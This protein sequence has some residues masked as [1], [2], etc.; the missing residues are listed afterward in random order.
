MAGGLS[1][2]RIS[3]GVKK[4]N[5]VKWRVI[6]THCCWGREIFWRYRSYPATLWSSLL[7]RLGKLFTV[8]CASTRAQWFSLAFKNSGWLNEWRWN[9]S[10]IS[11]RGS[12]I[13]AVSAGLSNSNRNLLKPAMRSQNNN[14]VLWSSWIT[15]YSTGDHLSRLI[16]RSRQNDQLLNI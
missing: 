6:C 13:L 11:L 5:T 4:E 15:E 2:V 16:S 10:R 1:A 14:S 8:D 12:S 3:V 9:C 7:Q